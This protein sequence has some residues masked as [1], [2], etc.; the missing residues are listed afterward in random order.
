MEGK[1]SSFIG[2]LYF[3]NY[4]REAIMKKS[5]YVVLCLVL[6]MLFTS[7]IYGRS[8]INDSDENNPIATKE[9]VKD[10]ED[11]DEPYETVEPTTMPTP[12]VL[13]KQI[14]VVVARDGYQEFELNPVYNTLIA[15]GYE[16]II[17]S[18]VKE[19]AIGLR[20][21]VEVE[22]TFNELMGTNIRSIIVIGGTGV[23]ALWENADLHKLL[24]EVYLKGRVVGA[25]CLAP[26]A[27]SKAGVLGEGSTACWY[28]YYKSDAE[29]V[30]GGVIDSGQDVT[31][32]GNIITS[33]GPDAAQEFADKI[34]EALEG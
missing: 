16:L 7:C 19:T 8:H 28:N 33:N 29:M 4:D 15:A 3:L 22:A 1:I 6:V 30:N 21:T 17:V 9:I 24:N 34:V 10:V 11:S 13:T 20:E 32:E 2:V 31:V 14:A 23:E 12:E 25:I 5:M 27:L 26:I 18:D